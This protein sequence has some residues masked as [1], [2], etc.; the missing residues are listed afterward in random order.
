[1]ITIED[2]KIYI[3]EKVC[4]ICENTENI[5]SHHTLPIHLQ[6]KRNVVVPICQKCHQKIN[7]NDI[8]SIKT[9]SY[10]ILKDTKRTLLKNVALLEKIENAELP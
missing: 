4:W 5:T 10:S 7:N 2:K 6:P 9:L 8:A 1:M 3:S